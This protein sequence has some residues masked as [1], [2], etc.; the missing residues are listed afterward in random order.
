MTIFNR[1]SIVQLALLAT[2]TLFLSITFLAYK[3]I[4]QLVQD[5]SVAE[6]DKRI[7]TLVSA[8]ERVAHHHAVERGL[9]A[10]FLG[11]P[12]PDAKQKVL[13]QRKNADQAFQN[14]KSIYN[15]KWPEDLGI[16]A[17][18]QPL[19]S[20]ETKKA[21][22]REAVDALNGADAF[23]YYSE[24]N[25]R[26]L[27]AANAFTILL[28]DKNAKQHLL[29][30]LTL[31]GLKERLGQRRGKINAVLAKRSINLNTRVEVNSYSD[32]VVYLTE[33]LTLGL[34]REFKSEFVNSISSSL[35]T[36]VESIAADV[37]STDV[38]F[39]SL[40]DNSEWFR[41][42]TAQIGQVAK[43]LSSIFETAMQN[44]NNN[45]ASA[46][47]SLT[48]IVAMI[49]VVFLFIVL[50]YRVL[51]GIITKQLTVLVSNLDKIA[52]K[53]DLTIDVSMSTSNELGE[54]SRSV[55]TTILALRD[56]IRGLGESIGTSTR[57]S[58]KLEVACAQMLSDAE[59][60]QQLS[61]NI[62]S[63]VEE[64]A[65]T[66]REIAR[67]SL[68][69][70]NASKSLDNLA[71]QSLA[72]ND[73]IRNS[74][75]VLSNDIRGVQAN[76]AQMELK[77]TE[78][79]TILE[80]IN[81]LS[82]QTNLL[83]LNAAIEAA[84]AGEHG[85]GFAVVADEVRKLAQSSRESSDKISTLLVSLK[86]A[87][88]VVVND[89]NK[90]VSSISASMDTTL[91]GRATAEKV[92]AAASELEGMANNMSSAAEQQSVTTEE[93]AKDVV[94]VEEAARHELYIAE[95]L[96]ELSNEMQQNNDLLQ[97]TID[98]FKAD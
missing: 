72:A 13:G 1:L 10:G 40:P 96:S 32:D 48:F 39:S 76:A 23:S 24:L 38:D 8:V 64:V 88:V 67:S 53:G 17:L 18:L 71:D 63:A 79:G 66:S 51:I 57:L 4:N 73:N 11:N 97:R 45:V 36:Q 37:V 59:N 56:L 54:I 9:T 70:L 90:N 42:A 87:S 75:D 91:E 74:M 19:M 78:I 35:S 12:S 44:S 52:Q 7:V 83:A 46:N 98:S 16:D 2:G 3:N 80:T 55:N 6:Q 81:T 30:G 62:A 84:R 89:I 95:Q 27:N 26:A 58:G 61:A 93:V 94:S 41:L 82:D 65:V 33:K 86:E 85:R 21:S 20:V 49:V 47:A 25:K 60:T 92:K 68:D 5:I 34:K 43:I 69:T 29:Q 15:E 28:S 14:L 31:A 22:I 50:I 77:V